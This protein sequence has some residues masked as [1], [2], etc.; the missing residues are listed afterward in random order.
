MKTLNV[1]FHAVHFLNKPTLVLIIKKRDKSLTAVSV[2]IYYTRSFLHVQMYFL[3]FL[4]LCLHLV[5][6]GVTFQKSFL[7]A[8][9][10]R[11]IV[12]GP[13][14]PSSGRKLNLK[15]P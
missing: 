10:H 12:N 7:L 13:C 5:F 15:P 11:N 3:P 1:Y 2:C 9:V 8:A 14:L 4:I 6:S